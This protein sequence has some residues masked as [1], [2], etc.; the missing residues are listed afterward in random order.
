MLGPRGARC[1]NSAPP[2]VFLLLPARPPP[3]RRFLDIF[4]SLY[5]KAGFTGFPTLFYGA[6]KRKS[7]APNGPRPIDGVSPVNLILLALLFIISSSA[8]ASFFGSSRNTRRARASGL[9]ALDSLEIK[10]AV[11]GKSEKKPPSAALASRGGRP[12][13]SETPFGL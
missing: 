6:E 7:G 4:L 9:L 10:L 12:V 2:G 3:S 11:A 8:V 1:K 5:K 13:D